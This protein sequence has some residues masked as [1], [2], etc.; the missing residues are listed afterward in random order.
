LGNEKE[1]VFMLSVTQPSD[2]TRAERVAAKAAYCASKWHAFFVLGVG[3]L[4]VMMGFRN[5]GSL[6]MQMWK[7]VSFAAIAWIA[8]E[9]FGFSSLLER[10]DAEIR[11][12][13]EAIKV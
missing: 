11:R 10:R 8:W 13:K 5:G 3:L 4:S 12:L 6:D 1:A 7:G 2:L 9:H